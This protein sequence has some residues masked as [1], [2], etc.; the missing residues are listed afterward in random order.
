ML[1]VFILSIILT[2]IL[3]VFVLITFS[4]LKIEI[5]KFEADNYD[6]K[7]KAVKD[8][9]LFVRL[10]L[11]NKIRWFG[12]KIDK[13][14]I[15]TL[16]EGYLLKLLDK[17]LGV[18]KGE[19]LKRLEQFIIENRRKILS[20]KFLRKIGELN[21]YVSKINLKF[22]VGTKNPILTAFIVTFLSSVISI[23]IGKKIKHFRKE[24]YRY[25]I[26]PVYINKNIFKIKV[27]CIIN[28][29]MVHIM[30]MIY[31]FSKRRSDSKYGRTSNR[32]TYD[33]SHE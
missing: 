6:K 26:N 31:V 27:N 10:Y 30:N 23:L 14:R 32:R 29:K 13:E 16:K 19:E 21:V 3:L 12:I 9:L 20:K 15:E 2:I 1:I 22:D 8:Y 25:L 17:K 28:V 7:E 5:E 33:Y 18:E 24:N 4:T 11:F